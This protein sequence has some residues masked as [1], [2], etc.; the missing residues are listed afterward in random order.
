[1]MPG[2]TVLNCPSCGAPV[3][4]DSIE[5]AFCGASL[6]VLSVRPTPEGRGV[7]ASQET[8]IRGLQPN[9][10]SAFLGQAKI[11]RKL[12]AS[13]E[14]ALSRG[15]VLG[16]I[17]LCG[18]DGCGKRTLAHIIANEM[19]VSNI[20]APDGDSAYELMKARDTHP[21]NMVVPSRRDLEDSPLFYLIMKCTLGH[22]GDIL[23]VDDVHSLTHEL[24]EILCIMMQSSE[25]ELRGPKKTVRESLPRFTVVAATD[26]PSRVIPQ[27]GERFE[28]IYEFVPYDAETLA[29]LVKNRAAVLGLEIS[30]EAC[31]EIGR[32]S[33]GEIREACRLLD[34]ASDYAETRGE[35]H[36]TLEITRSAAG[37]AAVTSAQHQADESS[38]D[39]AGGSAELVDAPTGEVGPATQKD[40]DCPKCGAPFQ[41][42]RF[43]RRCGAKL[44]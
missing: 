28:H 13:I 25:L 37:S 17:L 35:N 29:Q 11:K 41:V 19:G 44:R 23:F 43:C 34:R 27:L 26:Q 22:R 18:P 8:S 40:F 1:M 15:E 5:C 21:R 6:E 14:S 7:L 16:H 2:V 33:R 4:R 42:K 39:R 30:R 3:E 32:C 12:A 9:S 10:L 38:D 31:V 36:L 24:Q 20:I